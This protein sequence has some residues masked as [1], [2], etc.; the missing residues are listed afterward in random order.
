MPWP[1]SYY[2]AMCNWL[3]W[4]GNWQLWCLN[5]RPTSVEFG[6]VLEKRVRY[7]TSTQNV[8]GSS[9]KMYSLNPTWKLAQPNHHVLFD[10]NIVTYQMYQRNLLNE[11]TNL[12]CDILKPQ[13]PVKHRWQFQMVLSRHIIEILNS[14]QSTIVAKLHPIN[15]SAISSKKICVIDVKS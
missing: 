9:L 8:F 15:L 6:Q 4:H 13:S 11:N 10:I 1:G 12:G 7:W 2:R 14:S 3:K 5:V